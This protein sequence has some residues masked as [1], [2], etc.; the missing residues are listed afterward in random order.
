MFNII[1]IFCSLSIICFTGCNIK[2]NLPVCHKE[3]ADY[4]ITRGAFRDKWYDY[5]E[6]GQS[7][8][9][10]ECYQQA[11]QAFEM[12]IKKRPDDQRMARAYGMHLIDY[13]PHRELG[14]IY[15]LVN[16]YPNALKELN[17]SIQNEPSAKASYY[18]DKVRMQILLAQQGAISKP[19]MI[20]HQFEQ[21]N[22]LWTASD[23]VIISGIA[24]DAAFIKKVVISGQSLFM[25]GAQKRFSFEEQLDLAEGTHEMLVM[26]ENLPGKTTQR[27]LV[28]HVDRTGPVIMLQKI[29]PQKNIEGIIFDDSGYIEL[30]VDEKAVSVPMG[31]KVAFVVPW[32]ANHSMLLLAKDKAGNQTKA[33]VHMNHNRVMNSSRWLASKQTESFA[34]TIKPPEII[35]DHALK[36]N[37]VYSDK[38]TISGH[39][40]SQTKILSLTINQHAFNHEKGHRIFFSKT[41]PLEIGENLVVINAVDQTGQTFT[42][43]MILIRKQKEVFKRRHR[44]GIKLYP[45][46]FLERSSETDVFYTQLLKTLHERKR[47]RIFVSDDFQELDIQI[48]ANMNHLR[49]NVYFLKGIIY[50]NESS[51]IEIVGRVFDSQSQ[52]IDYVDVYDELNPSVSFSEQLHYLADRMSEKF[53]RTFPL[54]SGIVTQVSGSGY[55]IAPLRWYHGKGSLRL[56]SS[57]ILFRPEAPEMKLLSETIILGTSQVK[58]LKLHDF[59]IHAIDNT[60]ATGDQVITQ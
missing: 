42:K 23:P 43:Q 29:V 18:L 30:F 15:F 51:G 1:R 19:E 25:D 55:T 34:E 27:K 35:I 31:K 5:Y 6:M 58:Q 45:F 9:K 26:A 21:S 57:F 40:F 14:I 38:M 20:I 37:I 44:M 3:G 60:I 56:G 4:C 52:L 54:V 10:G 11:I 36:N 17:R 41:I 28:L 22:I 59:D 33:L 53:H 47:F 12:A 49:S 7:C 16:D 8:C 24:N 2:I 39:V 32:N 48:D 13:F 50:K 46:E